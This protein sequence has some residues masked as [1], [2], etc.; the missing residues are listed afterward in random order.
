MGN[1]PSRVLSNVTSGPHTTEQKI[2]SFPNSY[3]GF[4]F[5]KWSPIQSRSRFADGSRSRGAAP[6]RPRAHVPVAPNPISPT[7]ADA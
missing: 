6:Y 1:D 2:I 7:M 3:G 5:I 4:L